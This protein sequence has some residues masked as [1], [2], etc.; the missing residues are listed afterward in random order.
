MK[1]TS[2]VGRW[3]AICVIGMAVGP[4]MAEPYALPDGTQVVTLEHFRECDAC[5]EMVVLPKGAFA[6][7]A[8]PE[9]SILLTYLRERQGED[10]PGLKHERPVHKVEIDRAVAMGRNE[11]THNEFLACVSA[12]G[13][14]HQPDPS[15]I[16]LGGDYVASGRHPVIDVSAEDGMEYTAWLNGLVGAPGYRLPTEAEWEYAAR[17]GTNRR[18]AEGDVLR[19]DQV[20]FYEEGVQVTYRQ[21]PVPVNELDAENAWGLRHVSGNVQERTMSCYAFRHLG[22]PTSSAYLDHARSDADCRFVTKGDAYNSG[23]DVARP[24]SRGHARRPGVRTRYAGF[25]LVREM[26]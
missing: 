18:F 7:G 9:Q 20:R 10:V 1:D 5:P 15:V 4:T 12:G 26:E 3:L 16:V 19:H 22:L 8:P 17:G 13:C 2:S 25:R 6:M 11:V 23:P 21:Y 24:A 14:S